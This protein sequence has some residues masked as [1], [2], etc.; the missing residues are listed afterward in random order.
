MLAEEFSGL[1]GRARAGDER[2]FARLFR[3]LNPAVLRY[4][5]VA[6]PSAAE[7]L[8]AETWLEVARGLRRFSGTENGFRAWVLTIARHRHVDSLRFQ[9]R[10]PLEVPSGTLPPEPRN[11][12]QAAERDAEEDLSTEAALRLIANLSA[13]QAEV[14]V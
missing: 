11:A 7:D 8:G 2:A 14:V 13:P 5:R 4:F 3:D 6:A 9:G 12:R 1:L 10:R